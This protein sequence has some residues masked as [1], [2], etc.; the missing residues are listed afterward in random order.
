MMILQRR[1]VG[2]LLSLVLIAGV[3]GTGLGVGIAVLSRDDGE[4]DVP[5]SPEEAN[6]TPTTAAP[7]PAAPAAPGQLGVRVLGALLRPAKTE[8]GQARRRARLN[9]RV[10][11]ENQGDSAVTPERPVLLVAN[12]QI[13]TD[14]NADSP[15][16]NF[17]AIPPGESAT[18]TLRFETGG[19]ATTALQQQGRA[20]LSIAGVTRSFSVRVGD[21]VS[22]PDATSAGSP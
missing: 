18:V 14:S 4:S 21:P 1:G 3:A 22:E 6:A 8:S 15:E 20:R 11:A 19:D 9:V 13:R 16:T 12:R 17:G 2:R 5:A 7:A 10:R